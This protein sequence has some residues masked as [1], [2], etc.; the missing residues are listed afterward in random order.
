MIDDKKTIARR[1]EQLEMENVALNTSEATARKTTCVELTLNKILRQRSL[2]IERNKGTEKRSKSYGLL[3]GA[4]R[5]RA[6][7]LL[8]KYSN[9]ETR[10]NKKRCKCN[11]DS[12]LREADKQ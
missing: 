9:L 1:L 5:Q 6:I 4:K 3:R 2:E 7:Y 12:S 8:E 10:D 11:F